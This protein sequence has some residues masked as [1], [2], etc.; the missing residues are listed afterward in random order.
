MEQNKYYKK[1][2]EVM[3]DMGS[4]HE[5]IDCD[6]DYHSEKGCVIVKQHG[7]EV[8]FFPSVR[9]AKIIKTEVN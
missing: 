6:F 3:D 2:V 8:A 1:S 7:Q 9:Y 4:Q 5:F